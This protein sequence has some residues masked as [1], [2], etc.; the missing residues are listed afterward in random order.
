M[1]FLT[2]GQR[3]WLISG[4][5]TGPNARPV[6]GRYFQ[7]DRDQCSQFGTPFFFKQWGEWK[8]FPGVSD[9]FPKNVDT[10]QWPDKTRSYKYGSL[11]TGNLLDG[12]VHNTI[13]EFK[14]ATPEQLSLF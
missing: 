2:L 1:D 3:T 5:E 4:G 14:L 8:W 9:F 7:L 6:H 11:K 13:P 10:V 12:K